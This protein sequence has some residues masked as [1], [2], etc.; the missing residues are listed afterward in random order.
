MTVAPQ[1]PREKAAAWLAWWECTSGTAQGRDHALAR[2]NSQDAMELHLSEHAIVGV[3]ADG[4]GSARH[5]ETGARLVATL[6]ARALARWAAEPEPRHAR[7]AIHAAVE[8]VLA[9]LG[10]MASAHG[11]GAAAWVAEHL[12]A[13]VLA[14]V[15]TPERA[16]VFRVGDGIVGINGRMT[17]VDAPDNA[18]PYLAYRLLAL[19]GRQVRLPTVHP[20]VEWEGP[21]DAL[22]SVV[23]ATDGAASLPATDDDPHATLR[24]WLVDD[25]LFARPH[26]LGR[27][28]ALLARDEQVVDWERQVVRRK[29]GVLVDDTTVLLL[30]RRTS[31]QEG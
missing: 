20:V 13:T 19:H 5:S 16:I 28:L 31:L 8:E 29:A 9:V 23:L 15:V 12:L 10:H 22:E 4:C 7:R 18:P 1:L 11:S 27:R 21:S 2:R 26:A 6:L 14:V 30:R 3:L 24:G 25:A 17:T